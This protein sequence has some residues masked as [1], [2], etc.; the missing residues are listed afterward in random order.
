MKSVLLNPD[1]IAEALQVVQDGFRQVAPLILSRVGTADHTDKDDGSPV[2]ATDVEVEEKLLALLGERFP[3]VPVYGEESGYP[4]DLTG[5]FWLI[6][7]IDG[8]KSFIANVPAFTS[9]A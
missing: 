7:P 6:D 2:T 4:A 5:A 3:D 9:M 8:T 1:Q